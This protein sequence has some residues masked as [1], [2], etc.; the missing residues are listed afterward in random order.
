M[1]SWLSQSAALLSGSSAEAAA[2]LLP[3]ALAI[4]S[5]RLTVVLGSMVLALVSVY[6]LVAP[7]KMAQVIAIAFYSA[8]LIIAVSGIVAR[9]KARGLQ[10]EIERLRREIARLR[11]DVNEL[12]L[13]EQ[14]RFL[15]ELKEQ[16][17]ISIPHASSQA[18]ASGR[19]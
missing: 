19:L 13:S 7:F 17:R 12:S 9:Q 18:G 2:T 11:R 1:Q 8:S 5:K 10:N 6:T 14:R 16:E 15:K 3:G 4:F